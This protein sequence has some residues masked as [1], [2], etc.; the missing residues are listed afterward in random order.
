MIHGIVEIAVC[1]GI[2]KGVEFMDINMNG[3]YKISDKM[4]VKEACKKYRPNRVGMEYHC[5]NWTFYP[6]EFR[7]KLYM[8][9][10]YWSADS[11]SIEV[12]ENNIDDFKLVAI[13]DDIKQ[14]AMS[15]V[16]FYTSDDIIWLAMDSMGSDRPFVHKDTKMSSDIG[17][18]VLRSEIESLYSDAEWKKDQI[19]KI[20]KGEDSRFDTFNIEDQK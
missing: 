3:I 6:R 5:M 8:V 4:T 18:K 13:K 19:A 10:T 20:L 1:M 2:T 9:D 14:I 12:D 16:K 11:F 17:V 7:S 15:D